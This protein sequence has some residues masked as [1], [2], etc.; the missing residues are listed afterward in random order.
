MRYRGGE[1]DFWIINNYIYPKYLVPSKSEEL[2]RDTED[3]VPSK[4]GKLTRNPEDLHPQPNRCGN[5]KSR[6]V[7]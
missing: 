6:E 1:K 7:F 5:L 4:R 3:L 2:A